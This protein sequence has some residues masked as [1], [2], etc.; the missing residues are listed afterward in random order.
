M[1]IPVKE[2]CKILN[3]SP[4]TVYAQHAQH[5]GIPLYR[6]GEVLCISVADCEAHLQLAKPQRRKREYYRVEAYKRGA[7]VWG[8]IRK[9][10]EA[11][12]REALK[13]YPSLRGC[14]LV[15]EAVTL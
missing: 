6:V 14:K 8:G 10:T 1:K 3:K 4:Y 2:A 12:I 15:F 7:L 5:G 11:Q 9:G 13:I